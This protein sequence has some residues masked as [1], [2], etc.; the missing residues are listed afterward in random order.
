MEGNIHCNNANNFQVKYYIRQFLKGPMAISELDFYSPCG[1][2]SCLF[3]SLIF[4]LK[5]K[6]RFSQIPNPSDYFLQAVP[7]KSAPDLFAYQK[8]GLIIK[9]RQKMLV[10]QVTAMEA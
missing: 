1:S 2:L 3:S 9:F 10:V 5:K 8:L 4:H 6:K 7:S